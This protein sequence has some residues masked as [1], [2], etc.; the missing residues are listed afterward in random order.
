MLRSEDGS[1]K[2]KLEK[3]HIDSDDDDL[4]FED[5]EEE[6]EEDRVLRERELKRSHLNTIAKQRPFIESVVSNENTP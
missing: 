3:S 6:E 2:N 1:I 4:E 5:A